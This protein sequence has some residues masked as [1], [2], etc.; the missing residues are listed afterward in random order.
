MADGSLRLPP[1]R[2]VGGS[3]QSP[4]SESAINRAMAGLKWGWRARSPM[5]PLIERYAHAERKVAEGQRAI[6]CQRVLIATR[7]ALG[8]NPAKSQELLITFE[9][10]QAIFEGDLARITDDP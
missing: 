5:S 7:K 1:P 9:Q 2:L 3:T 6:D 8:K 4:D 10:L